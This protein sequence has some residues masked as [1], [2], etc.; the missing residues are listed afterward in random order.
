[1]TVS[2]NAASARQDSYCDSDRDNGKSGDRIQ[3]GFNKYKRLVM[4]TTLKSAI[5]ITIA[6]VFIA[7]KEIRKALQHCGNIW[8]T[9]KSWP[10]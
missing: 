5:E 7:Q 2:S 1:M 3:L 10:S 8:V 4:L 6:V 9:D